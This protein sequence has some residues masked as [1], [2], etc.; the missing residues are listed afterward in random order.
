[1]SGGVEWSEWSE[2]SKKAEGGE[3]TLFI[4]YDNWDLCALA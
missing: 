4:Y 3:D 2:W 1:M